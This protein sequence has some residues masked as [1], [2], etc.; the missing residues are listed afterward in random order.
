MVWLQTIYWRES[1]SIVQLAMEIGF[2]KKKNVI[3]L[4]CFGG[5]EP[6]VRTI[7]NTL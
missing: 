1:P 2:S 6:D 7:Y 4:Y 3:A 5:A